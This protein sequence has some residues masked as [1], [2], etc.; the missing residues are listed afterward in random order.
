MTMSFVRKAEANDFPVLQDK[1]RN[2]ENKRLSED[3]LRELFSSFLDDEN[4]IFLVSTEK[5]AVN[6]FISC[7]IQTSLG[8]GGNIAEIHGFGIL[9]EN[10]RKKIGQKLIVSLDNFLKDHK[11]IRV[12]MSQKNMGNQEGLF[13][14]L[15]FKHEEC[16]QVNRMRK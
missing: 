11:V 13:E 14:K 16:K 15:G 6:G 2:S 4:V 10:Q 9:D 7:L 8:Y 1:L 5:N 12:E 3:E